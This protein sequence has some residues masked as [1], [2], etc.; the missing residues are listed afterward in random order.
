MRIIFAAVVSRA[1]LIAILIFA[2][3]PAF[4]QAFTSSLTGLV[5]DPSGGAVP[6]A[7][8]R[9]KSVATSEERQ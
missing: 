8:V 5:T 6:N 3:H 1:L 4:G 7:T 2:P 9:I